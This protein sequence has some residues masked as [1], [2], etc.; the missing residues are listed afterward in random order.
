MMQIKV[1]NSSEMLVTTYI[2]AYP[3]RP[4]S[5]FTAVKLYKNEQRGPNGRKS[6][7]FEVGFVYRRSNVQSRIWL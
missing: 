1:A 3:K 6:T 4:Q 7:N 2:V 5:K